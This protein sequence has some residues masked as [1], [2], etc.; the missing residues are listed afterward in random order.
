MLWEIIHTV[1]FFYSAC[2]VDFFLFLIR[3]DLFGQIWS[4]K[5]NWEF[6][7][8]L[9]LI[10]IYTKFHGDVHCFCSWPEILVLENFGTKVQNCLFKV[11]F[12]SNVKNSVLMFIF[13]C[14]R[15]EVFLFGK[16]A[17]KIKNICWSWNWKLTGIS[18][19]HLWFCFFISEKPYLG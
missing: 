11:K 19:S 9:S 15:Q 16:I 13:F 18:R 3:N 1:R 10:W 12:D 6:K 17:S 14:F 7:L 5:Q 4:K 8:V 2:Y